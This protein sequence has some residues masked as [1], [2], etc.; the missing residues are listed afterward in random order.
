MRAKSSLLRRNQNYGGTA[1]ASAMKIYNPNQTFDNGPN[2]YRDIDMSTLDVTI[3]SPNSPN[4]WE[5][6]TTTANNW[7]NQNN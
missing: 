7:L 6:R 3:A 2:M 4:R 5:R 1:P